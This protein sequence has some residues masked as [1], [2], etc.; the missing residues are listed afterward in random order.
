[1]LIEA[2]GQSAIP[3]Q[4]EVL[5]PS[6]SGST[7]AASESVTTMAEYINSRATTIYGGTAEI[8]RS[9]IAKHVLGL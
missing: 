5:A 9:I 7:A 8:Q 2:A 4:S 3:R 6:Y 1:L